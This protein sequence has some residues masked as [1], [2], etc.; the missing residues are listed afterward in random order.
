MEVGA[1]QKKRPFTL[2]DPNTESLLD[3]GE[4]AWM[5]QGKRQQV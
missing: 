5:Q 1:V 4:Q 3:A 2:D